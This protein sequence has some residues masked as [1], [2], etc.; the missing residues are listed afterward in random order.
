[1]QPEI[2]GLLIAENGPRKGEKLELREG[3]AYLLGR[4]R[5]ASSFIGDRSVSRA[6]A[7]ITADG[8]GIQLRNLGRNGTIID[9]RRIETDE[10]VS[11][12]NGSI[13]ELG[14][15][16]FRLEIPL[17]GKTMLLERTVLIEPV[18][19]APVAAP[20]RGQTMEMPSRRKRKQ[21]EIIS[22]PAAKEPPLPEASE[23]NSAGLREQFVAIWDK[24]FQSTISRISLALFVIICLMSIFKSGSGESAA[25]AAE[26]V[27]RARIAANDTLFQLLVP[28]PTIDSKIPGDSL[29]K[30]MDLFTTAEKRFKDRT[31]QDANIYQSIR[32]WQSG[33]TLLG[34]YRASDGLE[35]YRTAI[36]DGRRACIAL[37]DRLRSLKKSVLIEAYKG[38][39]AEAL[40]LVETMMATAVDIHHWSSKWARN[41]KVKLK[42]S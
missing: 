29:L 35:S 24:Y 31:L 28:T 10:P 41:Y 27:E 8:F 26:T 22:A 25:I 1:M 20:R 33:I 15:Y 18:P 17:T 34:Q 38:N 19:E 39:K 4:S 13:I 21:L 12:K 7:E 42:S 2:I 40:N 32:L 23:A 16:R 11:L 3:Q 37:E 5:E 30:A 14:S 9:E 6:H 36:G